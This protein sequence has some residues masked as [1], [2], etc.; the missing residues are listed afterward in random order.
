M[1]THFQQVNVK[2][3]AKDIGIVRTQ[4]SLGEVDAAVHAELR[5]RAEEATHEAASSNSSRTHPDQQVS[6]M[7]EKANLSAISV[8][9]NSSGRVLVWTTTTAGRRRCGAPEGEEVTWN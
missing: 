3:N 1:F 5:R 4:L 2:M 9:V 8:G 7:F 6:D